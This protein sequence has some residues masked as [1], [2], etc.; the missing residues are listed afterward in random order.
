MDLGSSLSSPL[1]LTAALEGVYEIS[2]VDLNLYICSL[3]AFGIASVDVAPIRPLGRD[4]Q[5]KKG[6]EPN[7]CGL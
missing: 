2:C 4:V 6:C 3:I 5:F 7:F 1:R